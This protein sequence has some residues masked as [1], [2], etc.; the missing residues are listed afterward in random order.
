MRHFV[1]SHR[2]ER[3]MEAFKSEDV[4]EESEEGVFDTLTGATAVAD[5]EIPM[6]DG[7]DEEKNGKENEN[8]GPDS[9]DSETSSILS[10]Y[11]PNKSSNKTQTT[12]S[13]STPIPFEFA[14][15]IK[16]QL[17]PHHIKSDLMTHTKACSICTLPCSSML[18]IRYYRIVKPKRATPPMNPVPGAEEAT[19]TAPAIHEMSFVCSKACMDKDKNVHLRML[20]EVDN[21]PG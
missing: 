20:Y 7:V 21:L 11:R 2:C 6:E 5:A 12:T 16:R 13:Q 18:D 10:L 8:D 19:T 14:Q 4:N 1:A 9:D 15:I 17:L 3:F